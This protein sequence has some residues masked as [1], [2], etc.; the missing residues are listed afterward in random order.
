MD[1]VIYSI[2]RS[3]CQLLNCERA[4]AEPSLS[5]RRA[6]EEGERD[7]T[8]VRKVAE[9]EIGARGWDKDCG[10]GAL[11][12]LLSPFDCQEDQ[13]RLLKAKLRPGLWM[14]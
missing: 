3:N 8:P 11:R 2:V 12:T 5:G 10:K 13:Q 14:L 1:R 6:C 9:D 4:L 7:V